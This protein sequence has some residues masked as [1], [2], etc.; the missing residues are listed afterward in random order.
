MMIQMKSQPQHH[1]NRTRRASMTEWIDGW[2]LYQ[3]R[4]LPSHIPPPH[5]PPPP[6]GVAL[7]DC[8]SVGR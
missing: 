6:S 7:A 2:R 5:P 1:P 8:R 4:L 3:H